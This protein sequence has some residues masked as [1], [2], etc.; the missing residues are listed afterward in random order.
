MDI[1]FSLVVQKICT[2]TETTFISSVRTDILAEDLERGNGLIV[3]DNEFLE[4]R[5]YTRVSTIRDL[6][7]VSLGQTTEVAK[8]IAARL[9]R[10]S[11][12]RMVKLRPS[13]GYVGHR[14]IVESFF[15]GEVYSKRSDRV[16]DEQLDFLT[17]IRS[18]SFPIEGGG[19]G[20][21]PYELSILDKE[22]VRINAFRV[23]ESTMGFAVL[24][25]GFNDRCKGIIRILVEIGANGIFEKDQ[26]SIIDFT[27]DKWRVDP[28]NVDKSKLHLTEIVQFLWDLGLNVSVGISRGRK[29]LSP[30]AK[31]SI[32]H[33]VNERGDRLVE[34]EY[35]EDDVYD[36][37]EKRDVSKEELH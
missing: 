28:T 4:Y 31:D 37:P 30:H 11:S 14:A 35:D 23:L 22:R 10:R 13:S 25:G 19:I 16:T 15:E 12:E 1:D 6:E 18:G 33:I 3:E 8:R 9:R 27:V 29:L 32:D 5:R 34:M 26:W 20:K 24:P 36:A 21:I 2:E 17:M 7:H